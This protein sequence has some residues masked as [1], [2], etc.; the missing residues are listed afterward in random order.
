M[1]IIVTHQSPDLDALASV[2]LVRRF[3]RGWREATVEFVPSGSTLNKLPP[4]KNPHIMHVDTGFGMFDHHQNSDFT[5]A[6]KKIFEFLCEKKHLSE[7]DIPAVER[8]VEVVNRY[9]HFKEVFRSD[10]HD[11]MSDFSLAY[12]IMGLRANQGLAHKLVDL[13]ET[14]LDGIF[15][16]MK[17]KV[18]AE[19]VIKKAKKITTLWGKTL[20]METD[21]DFAM[22]LAFF[23]D[24]D[25]AVRYSPH[26]HNVSIKIHPRSSKKLKKL[27][28][29]IIKGDPD[30]QWFYHA[31][32]RMLLNASTSETKTLVT[33]Y[34]LDDL[35]KIIQSFT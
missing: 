2:W 13:S 27:Y 15:H 16:Y 34:S 21:N 35:V 8:I 12:I 7:T 14:S 3:R 28:E 26:Y 33:R 24:Y 23:H 10:A 6:T 11:D 29:K 4:D 19:K 5:C 9:D 31:S 25:M 22:K 18:N 20:I 32:G 1:K 17:N 30:A